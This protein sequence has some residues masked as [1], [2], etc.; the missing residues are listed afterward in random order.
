MTTVL[1]KHWALKWLRNKVMYNNNRKTL[2]ANAAIIRL[3]V[4]VTWAL[5]HDSYAVP[6]DAK[7]YHFR[8]LGERLSVSVL[9]K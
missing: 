4:P 7:G 6:V 8:A 1:D 3:L 5:I 9:H 2:H